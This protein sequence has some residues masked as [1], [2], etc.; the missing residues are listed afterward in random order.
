MVAQRWL[1]EEVAARA[2]LAGTEEAAQAVRVTVAALARRLDIPQR[3][4]LRQAVPGPERDAAFAAVPTVGGGNAEL[5]E[6]ISGYVGGTPEHVRYIARTV[7]S[8]IA[9]AEPELAREILAHLPTEFREL[10]SP[11]DPCP[12][13]MS[14]ATGAPAPLTP[15]ELDTALRLRPAWSG[16]GHRL[17]RTVTLPDDRLAQLLDRVQREAA[18][19]NH[20]IDYEQT[21]E[22]MTFIL[23]TRTRTAEA[24]TELDLTLADRIDVAIEAYR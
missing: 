12:E 11:P 3:R 13:R 5:L 8:R 10:F 24:V 16:D 15:S 6:E 4:R 19:L 21:G 2:R 20:R 23:R 7:L 14:T 9:E 17:L 22:G 1:V 18:E